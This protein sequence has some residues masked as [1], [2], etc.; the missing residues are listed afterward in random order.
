MP[1]TNHDCHGHVN[2]RLE[3]SSKS[4]MPF[5]RT[6]AM[7]HTWSFA[8]LQEYLYSQDGHVS[9]VLDLSF[10]STLVTAWLHSRFR[11]ILLLSSL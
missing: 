3:G 1:P 9:E 7:L 8:T 2:L 5:F 10:P 11:S 6:L 4:L